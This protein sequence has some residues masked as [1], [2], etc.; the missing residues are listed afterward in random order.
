MIN[1]PLDNLIDLYK[2]GKSSLEIAKYLGTTK[3]NVLK[4]LK[5]FPD[6][7]LIKRP[8]HKI[9]KEKKLIESICIICGNKVIKKRKVK[10]CSNKCIKTKWKKNNPKTEKQKEH[11]RKT[12]KYKDKKITD[13]QLWINKF[14]QM[15]I[16]YHKNNI[17]KLAVKLVNK[18]VSIKNSMVSRSKKCN[19]RCDI[20]VNDIREL[21]L[22]YYGK[23]CKYINERIIDYKNMTFDHI[24]PISKGGESTRNNIQIISRFSNNIKGS[25]DEK[26]LYIL[27]DWLNSVDSELKKDIMIR[28][29]KGLH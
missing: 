22:Q 14:E 15:L 11:R 28:L 25:L 19:V 7:N 5:Q 24:I 8:A 12:R 23:P 9:K 10:Y 4:K 21:I 2:S 29:A 20:T 18:S 6:W 1:I 16:L 13:R 27:L 17:K 3:W 26:S